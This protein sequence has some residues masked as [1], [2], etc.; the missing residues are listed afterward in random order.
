MSR[1]IC[2]CSRPML[3]ST[4]GHNQLTSVARM[5]FL[6]R[7]F[8]QNL[9]TANETLNSYSFVESCT[10]KMPFFSC[11]PIPSPNAFHSSS[12]SGPLTTFSATH[13]HCKYP[14]N[15]NTS[16]FHPQPTQPSRAYSSYTRSPVAHP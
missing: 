15:T 8:L 7:V 11:T 2:F 10:Y 1:D 5:Q 12:S 6:K 3:S 13:M 4:L 16:T 14:R 9:I